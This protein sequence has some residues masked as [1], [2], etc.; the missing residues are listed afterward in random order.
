VIGLLVAPAAVVASKR[1]PRVTLIE[2]VAA[3]AA[4][5]LIALLALLLARRA[6]LYREKT[7]GRAGGARTL[8]VGRTLGLIGICLAASACIALAFYA[9][10]RVF[11]S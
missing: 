10:L 8:R 9:A 1:V 6:R 11:L 4:S 7:L 2:A 5:G 3:I